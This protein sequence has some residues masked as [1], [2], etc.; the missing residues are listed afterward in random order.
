MTDYPKPSIF[1]I[2]QAFSCPADQVDGTFP[3]GSVFRQGTYKQPFSFKCGFTD[4][5]SGN[6][7][8]LE[9]ISAYADEFRLEVGKDTVSPGQM[10]GTE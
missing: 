3:G 4:P 1:D 7:T 9:A 6:P 8:S 5:V 10:P 2:D